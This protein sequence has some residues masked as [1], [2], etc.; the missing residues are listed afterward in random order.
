MSDNYGIRRVTNN[1]DRDGYNALDRTGDVRA[2]NPLVAKVTDAAATIEKRNTL[3]ARLFPDA[4]QREAAKGELALVKTEYQFRRE[5]LEIAR[6]TQVD[7]LKEACNQYLIGQKAEIRQQVASFLLAKTH[8]L[9]E[10]LDR[11]FDQFIASMERKMAAAE[12]ID[13][14]VIRNVRIAQ[15]ERD[16]EEFAVLQAELADRFR[17]IVSEGI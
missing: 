1:S 2:A 16:L 6:R 11:T 3:M 8:E 4:S 15:L 7:S 17:R 5:A 10:N 9:Q 12:A 13:R 14:A